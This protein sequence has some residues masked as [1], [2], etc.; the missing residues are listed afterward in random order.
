M[1]H[2]MPWGVHSYQ[3]VFLDVDWTLWRPATIGSPAHDACD[4][5]LRGV[6]SPLR[7]RTKSCRCAALEWLEIRCAF[8]CTALS[9][10][11][12]M[13]ITVQLARRL[14]TGGQ[15]ANVAY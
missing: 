13:L 2:E 7:R 10:V 5:I 6:T 15:K 11:L 3:C 8:F 12:I 9:R 4:G 14:L 1:L